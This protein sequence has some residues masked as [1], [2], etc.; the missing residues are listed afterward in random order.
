MLRGSLIAVV[1]DALIAVSAGA[2][3]PGHFAAY[4]A[5]VLTPQGAFAP[6][7]P[8]SASAARYSLRYGRVKMGDGARNNLAFAARVTGAGRSGSL[9]AG[10]LTCNGCWPGVTLGGE[11]DLPLASGE[12]GSARYSAEVRNAF[13]F[14][15]STGERD[16]RALSASVSVPLSFAAGTG[17]RI[18]PFISPGL[19][20]GRLS[21]ARRSESGV[22]LMAGLGLAIQ[23]VH[24]SLDATIGMHKV[25]IAEGDM[26]FGLAVM[27]GE[28]ARGGDGGG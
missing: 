10:L 26:T 18:A 15:F 2:Q 12:I 5:L 1:L 3:D 24:R 28:F 19:G 16:S 17:L 21:I 27:W 4:A 6:L 23:N 13:G 7:P 25:F 20:Y 11:L 22:R 8:V 14:A 9:T